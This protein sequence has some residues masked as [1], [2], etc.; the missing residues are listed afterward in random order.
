MTINEVCHLWALCLFCKI[1]PFVYP[2]FSNR[3]ILSRCLQHQH[4][5][6]SIFF[7]ARNSLKSDVTKTSSISKYCTKIRFGQDKPYYR[8]SSAVNAE[9]VAWVVK[10]I[11]GKSSPQHYHPSYFGHTLVYVMAV[12]QEIQTNRNLIS[13]TLRLIWIGGGG[14]GHKLY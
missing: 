14:G 1:K 4:W 9:R 6:C 3:T 7:R 11:L 13:L 2:S 12:F 5:F 8:K 10:C